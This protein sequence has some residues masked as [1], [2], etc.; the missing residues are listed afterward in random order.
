MLASHAL[1]RIPVLHCVG[2]GQGLF[3]ETAERHGQ[4][5]KVQRKRALHLQANYKEGTCSPVF[6]FYKVN[7]EV[8]GVWLSRT[9]AIC[10]PISIVIHMLRAFGERGIIGTSYL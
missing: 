9:L 3:L 2:G 4:H 5:R 7:P 10:I 8:I 6:L 1:P